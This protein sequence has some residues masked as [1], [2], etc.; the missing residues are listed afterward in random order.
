MQHTRP[1]PSG[2]VHSLAVGA[3][4]HSRGDAPQ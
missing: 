4:E 3:N 2:F 1:V